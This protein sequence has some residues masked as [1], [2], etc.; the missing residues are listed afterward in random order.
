[1]STPASAR[2]QQHLRAVP[3]HVEVSSGPAA[4]PLLERVD[5]LDALGDAVRALA[6]GAGG[7]VF[8]DA[9]AGLGKTALMTQA[10]Q[11]ARAAG[12]TV[13][14]AAPS[15]LERDFAYGAVRALLEAQLRDV[16]PRERA[17]LLAGSAARAGDLL[18]DGAG[19]EGDATVVAHSLLWV[20]DGLA[21]GQPLALLVDDAQWA[22]RSSLEV[23]AYL[24][25]RAP[26]VPLLLVVAARTAD[27]HSHWDLLAMIAGSAAA[28]VLRP[29]PLTTGG[30]IR[31]MRRLAPDTAIGVCREHCA[32]AVGNPWLMHVLGHLLAGRHAAASSAI[33]T[34]M[35]ELTPSARAMAAALAVLGDGADPQVLASVAGVGIAG[36][37]DAGDA[38]AAAGLVGPDRAGFP[39]AFI[40]TAIIGT[41]SR[42]EC[43]RLHSEAARA[44]L[45][46]GTE[47]DV[48]ANHLLRT[49]P[50]ADPEVVALLR[51]AAA[52][53]WRRGAPAAA[54]TYLRRALDERAPETDRGSV[55]AALATAAF[56][57]EDSNA[58]GYMQAALDASDGRLD[59]LA[60]V[61]SLS[62][63]HAPD[64]RVVEAVERA[65]A[66]TAGEARAAAVVQAARELGSTLSGAPRRRLL[67]AAAPSTECGP[68]AAR[69]QQAHEAWL[70][71]E[72][73][74]A[75]AHECAAMAREALAD[76]VLLR[77]ARERVGFHLCTRTL[78]LCAHPDGARSAV[79]AMRAEAITLGSSRLRA[80]AA[81]FATELALRT[82]CVT[83]AERE[84][85]TVIA[86]V[87]DR[88]G[89]LAKGAL[90]VLVSVLAERGAFDEAR[91]L[92]SQAHVDHAQDAELLL[93]AA[94]LELA[95]GDF[96]RAHTRAHHVGG[97][98][99]A[100]G[101]TNPALCPWR[102]LAALALAHVDRRTEAATLA[103][104]ELALARRF[105]AP[106]PIVAA[107]HAL[108]VAEP[109]PDARVALCEQALAVAEHSLAP[110]EA[111]RV[112]LELGN[113]LRRLGKRIEARA[114]L[115]RAL[116]DADSGGAVLAAERARRELVATGL[117][118]RRAQTEGA[119][120]LTPR[121]AE[122]CQLA[123][124][125]TSNRE[126]AQRLFLSI[127]TVE[128]H[129][130]AAYRKLAVATRA[131]LVEALTPTSAPASSP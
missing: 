24:A 88:T 97:M 78:V 115:Q 7:I 77:A 43:E 63:V 51:T 122:I 40:A 87:D 91:A 60:R 105:A 86:L 9:A 15:P 127:K 66:S 117:R 11:L 10:A 100:E 57:A 31:L 46:L 110:L 112:R 98:C 29:A 83:R 2:P 65:L 99:Q 114:P 61:A 62:A 18:L 131:E 107:L 95:A 37:A 17:R 111:T 50:Q 55:L 113:T 35:A 128:T 41:L 116:A 1:M 52:E 27:P 102:S 23:L 93:A 25:R 53:A 92:L 69:M 3:R 108:I 68:L 56:D 125:G 32:A 96:A 42:G 14:L 48:V 39:H 130:A 74:R 38:L 59:V 90:A 12:A 49:S 120:A 58:R 44:Q 21:T 33:R 75:D 76:G 8:I 54:A 106:A 28:T 109:D 129:L 73:G 26:D 22:D 71:V 67:R 85:R 72:Q 81:L 20:C 123:A 82:G 101:R 5:E 84:A 47:P 30:G 103:D 34:R 94:R 70:A 89:R 45:A 79:D 36:L 124:A 19:E 13:C 119:D 126:I 4:S 104:A 121:Q 64:D 16:P 6:A 80:G 118:P